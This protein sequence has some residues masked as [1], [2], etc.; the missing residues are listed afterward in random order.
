[1]PYVLDR[2]NT[3][4][5]QKNVFEDMKLCSATFPQTKIY[6]LIEEKGRERDASSS[7]INFAGSVLFN[8]VIV[9]TTFATSIVLM[10]VMIAFYKL[11]SVLENF[12]FI[13]KT[14]QNSIYILK[15]VFILFNTIF[16]YC[17]N[18]MI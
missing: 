17:Q 12:L 11:D 13:P 8:A 7:H 2:S 15:K 6:I 5:L 18:S 16:S 9:K 4:G 10:C 1:M 14:Y 3:H